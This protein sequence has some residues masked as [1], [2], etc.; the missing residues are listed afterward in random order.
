MNREEKKKRRRRR[1]RRRSRK[2]KGREKG[3][4]GEGMIGG[5][6]GGRRKAQKV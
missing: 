2:R 3:V 6:E 1:W 4:D 5:Y